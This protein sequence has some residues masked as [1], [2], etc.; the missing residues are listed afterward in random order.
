MDV[1]S[2]IADLHNQLDKVNQAIVLLENISTSRPRQRERP[3]TSFHGSSKAVNAD[4]MKTSPRSK[5][6]AIS[7]N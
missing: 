2:V 1:A 6:M 7:G 3:R 4:S 5:T